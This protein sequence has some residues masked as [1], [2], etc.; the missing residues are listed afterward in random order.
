M[1]GSGDFAGDWGRCPHPVTPSPR[2]LNPDHT[3]AEMYSYLV[4][5]MDEWGCKHDHLEIN[6]EVADIMRGLMQTPKDE[7]KP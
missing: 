5:A 4:E 6:R 2:T 7:S 3:D 1:T